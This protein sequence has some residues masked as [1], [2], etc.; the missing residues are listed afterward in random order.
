ME[1]ILP[2]TCRI[3]QDILPHQAV[4]RFIANDAIMEGALPDRAVQLFGNRL[5]PL[6]DH[7]GNCRGAQCAPVFP[8]VDLQQQMDM[9]GITA[10]TSTVTAGYLFGISPIASAATRPA[11]ERTVPAGSG[12]K[13]ISGDGP[14]QGWRTL[15]AATASEPRQKSC[16]RSRVQTVTKYAPARA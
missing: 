7:T 10:Q 11:A 16:W 1:A 9:I 14:C 13:R 3:R 5:F 2:P 6:L 4:F 12:A 8:A 15:C